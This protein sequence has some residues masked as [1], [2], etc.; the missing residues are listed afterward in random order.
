MLDE[1]IL[2]SVDN[3]NFDI[4]EYTDHVGECNVLSNLSFQIFFN[5]DLYSIVKMDSFENFVE[6]IRE[7]YIKNNPYHNDIHA[8]DVLQTCYSMLI[9]SNIKDVIKLDYFDIC[10][11]FISAII[12]DF[13]HPGLTNGFLIATKNKL[14]V[15]YNGNLN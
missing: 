1:N 8:A 2:E 15:D 13:K 4:F 3:T 11:F 9:H 5:Y 7:G 10:S 6:K 14:A 12:H